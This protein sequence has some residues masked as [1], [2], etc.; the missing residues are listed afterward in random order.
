MGAT[1]E[2][3]NVRSKISDEEQR[4][5]DERKNAMKINGGKLYQTKYLPAKFYQGKQT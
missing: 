4:A 2:L 3:V 1:V 5:A